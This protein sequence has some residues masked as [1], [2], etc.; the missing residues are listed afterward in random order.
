MNSLLVNFIKR[1]I[2]VPLIAAIITTA[3]LIFAG[4]RMIAKTS[5]SVGE[6]PSSQ[7]LDLTGYSLKSYN[8]FKQLKSDDLVA[9]I[10]C[11]KIG[12][13]EKAVVYD[14][15]EKSNI[16]MNKAS[17][18]PWNGGGVLFVGANTSEQFKS[19]HNAEVGAKFT[20]SFYDNETYTYKLK[21]IIPSAQAKEL[22][23]FIEDN[24][25]V[26]C[27]QYNDFK[28]LGNSY[29]YQVFIAERV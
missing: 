7:S 16:V 12:L 28:D 2:I 17:V 20:V 22:T 27:L 6:V 4:P 29:Y 1:A 5:V 3:V 19:L 13:N 10:K 25:L 26:L 23:S 11:E 21:K 18:E 15:S 24:R 14:S 8:T 9:T